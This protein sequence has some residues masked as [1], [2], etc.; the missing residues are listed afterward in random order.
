MIL[1]NRLHHLAADWAD[2][3]CADI[4][5]QELQD[6]VNQLSLEHS[7]TTIHQYLVAVRKVLRHALAMRVIEV[8]PEFPKIRINPQSRGA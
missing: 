1:R 6:L 7:T 5:Y 4:R 8:L 2:V 3:A